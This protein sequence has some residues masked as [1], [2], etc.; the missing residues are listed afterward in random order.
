MTNEDV[1]DLVRRCR[2]KSGKVLIPNKAYLFKREFLT[3]VGFKFYNNEEEI[4]VLVKDGKKVGGIYRMGTCDI[5]CVLDERY[6]NQHIMS[7]FFKSGIIREI[8]PENKSVKLCN[9]Y[10]R[11]EYEKKKHLAELL[12]MSVKNTDEIERFLSYVDEQRAKHNISN[13]E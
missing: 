9:V 6:R 1:L 3:R 12:G 5:H 4:I 11:E 2:L 13:E 10:T 8:W 7:D